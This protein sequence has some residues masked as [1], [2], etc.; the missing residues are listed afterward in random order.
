MFIAPVLR[1]EHREL[2][3]RPLE[4]VPRV[5]TAVPTPLAAPGDAPTS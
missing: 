1:P 3:A 2:N 4:R 5:S